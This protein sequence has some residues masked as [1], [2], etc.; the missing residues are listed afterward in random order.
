MRPL[1]EEDA[2]QL[3]ELEI[4]LF[5][6]PFNERTL[7][8][9]I[10]SGFGW[11]EGDLDGFV[12]CHRDEGLI[13]VMRLGVRERMQG[14]GIGR[15]LLERVLAEGAGTSLAVRKANTRARRL[16]EGCGF[17]IVGTLET[18]W[19]MFRDACQPSIQPPKTS[20]SL[21]TTS[22]LRSS[23][24]NRPLQNSMNPWQAQYSAK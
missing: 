9:L 24:A 20:V 17:Q 12:L 23:R 21:S 4:A 19:L 7:S 14:Q 2:E 16:Y 5:D 18:S 6:N 22:K 13:D 15:G 10:H 3:A 1:V 11:V 8:K